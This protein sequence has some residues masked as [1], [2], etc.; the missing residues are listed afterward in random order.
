[1]IYFLY[2]ENNY[3]V[4]QKLKSIIATWPTDAQ[5]ERY[6]GEGI[7]TQILPTIFQT[8]SLFSSKKYLILSRCSDNKPLWLAL[9]DYFD[10][11]GD[12]EVIF[13]EETPDK[14]TKTF[15]AFEK[16]AEVFAAPTLQA[17]EAL[18]W[19]QR[20]AKERQ[21]V[22]ASSQAK[23]VVDRVGT[24]TW[25]LHFAL[26]TLS[27]ASIIDDTLIDTLIP[28]QTEESVFALLDAAFAGSVERVRALTDDVRMQHDPYQFFGLLSQQIFQ[29]SLLVSSGESAAIVAKSIGVHPFP[30]QKLSPIA[31]KM[32]S[33]ELKKIITLLGECDDAIKRSGVEPWLVIEQ[34][35]LKLALVCKN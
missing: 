11:I 23:R 16:H 5:I 26:Q 7:T 30:L 29:L 28:A 32:S 33:H 18:Q 4:R 15:K 14:R 27:V 10:A 17:G 21:V 3:F 25:Q 22:L 8:L 35:L 2:G 9:V 20:E 12:N 31:K 1:M 34:T 13:V 6:D 19:L 24:D